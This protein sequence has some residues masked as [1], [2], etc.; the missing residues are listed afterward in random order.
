[1]GLPFADNHP[2]Q[3]AFARIYVNFKLFTKESMTSSPTILFI[4]INA[5]FYVSPFQP[6]FSI[7]MLPLEE[8]VYKLT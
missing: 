2:P 4:A 8:L 3:S 6:Y 7:F 5:F 1:M